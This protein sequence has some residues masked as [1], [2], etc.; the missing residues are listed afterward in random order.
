MLS[1]YLQKTGPAACAVG[2]F[3]Q[4]LQDQ[5]DLLHLQSPRTSLLTFLIFMKSPFPFMVLFATSLP[6]NRQLSIS[7]KEQIALFLGQCPKASFM[8]LSTLQTSEKHAAGCD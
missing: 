5:H 7:V 8:A 3:L 4:K 1:F 6:E 2:P